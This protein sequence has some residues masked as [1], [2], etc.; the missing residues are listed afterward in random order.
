MGRKYKASPKDYEGALY[1]VR[2]TD[3]AG[4]LLHTVYDGEVYSAVDPRKVFVLDKAA[5]SPGWVQSIE[6]G[7]MYQLHIYAVP[8]DDH[9]SEID[10]DGTPKTW[11][12]FFAGVGTAMEKCGQQLMDILDRFWQGNGQPDTTQNETQGKLLIATKK[13]STTTDEGWLLNTSGMYASRY[14]PNTVRVIFQESIGLIKTNGDP[15]FSRIDW[16]VQGMKYDGN[17][18]TPVF[19][20]GSSRR[21]QH[22]AL[23]VPAQIGGYDTYYF[24]VPYDLGQGSYTITLQFYLREDDAAPTKAITLR[25]E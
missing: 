1:A 13:Q 2:F 3:E 5:L 24:K 4:N 18:S 17:E 25:G 6:P 21:S 9:N 11:S 7:K 23:L 14:D 10:I 20:S 19:A 15:V 12:D 22:D 16:S 8:D